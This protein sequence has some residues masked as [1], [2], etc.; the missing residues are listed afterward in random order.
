MTGG[1]AAFAVEA[2]CHAIQQYSHAA[3]KTA[4]LACLLT[5]LQS[6]PELNF[7]LGSSDACQVI[8]LIT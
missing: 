3:A 2:H 4:T 6:L 7:T 5:E 8:W 1:I